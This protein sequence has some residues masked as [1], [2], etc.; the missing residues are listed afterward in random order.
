MALGLGACAALVVAVDPFFHYR[1]PDPESEVWFDQRYQTAGLIRSQDYET[2]LLGTSMVANFR[3]LWFDAYYD[4]STIKITFPNGGFHEFTQALDYAFETHPD[5]KRVIV[6]LDP[7]IL[8]RPAAEAPDELPAYLYD[9]NPFNDSPYLLNKDVLIRSLYV[10]KEK[11]AGET[12]AIQD[13]FLWDG[14]VFFSKELALAGYK[15]PDPTGT[16]LP[17][18]ALL[19]TCNENLDTIRTWL[20][21]HPDTEFVF[22]YPPYSILFWDKMNRLG[23]TEAMFSLLRDA[24]GK[25]LQYDNA[26]VHCF[27]TDIDTITDLENYA[28]HLHVAG[29]VTYAMSKQIA[30]ETHRLTQ[31][32][33][34]SKLDALHEFVVNYDYESIYSA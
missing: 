8:A 26:Q 33:Y 5:I 9:S 28:D 3:P 16:A 32:N 7:N 10:A 30:R 24:T 34:E 1:A 4:T 17:S 14:D 27:L 29:R 19:A 2:I 25:L 11:A 13:A 18:D 6:G 15:R 31:E 12:T 22:F 20:V 21:A 23:E